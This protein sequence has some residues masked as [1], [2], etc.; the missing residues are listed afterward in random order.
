MKLKIF[1]LLLIFCLLAGIFL[2]EPA[3]GHSS[4]NEVLQQR[5]RKTSDTKKG[6]KDADR[7]PARS[8]QNRPVKANFLRI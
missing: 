7:S 8:I 3:D 4:L 6:S 2:V 5:Y 1:S